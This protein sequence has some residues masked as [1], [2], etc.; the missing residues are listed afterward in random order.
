MLEFNAG[1][2]GRKLPIGFG[3][4]FIAMSFPSSNF[5]DKSFLVRNTAIKA[6]A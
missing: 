1:V 3:V 2:G 6:L 4:M 5:L